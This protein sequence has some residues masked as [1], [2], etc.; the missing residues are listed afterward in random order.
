MPFKL[1]SIT[2]AP[3]TTA[4]METP[5]QNRPCSGEELLSTMP[6][7]LEMSSSDLAAFWVLPASIITQSCPFKEFVLY[8]ITSRT[9]DIQS[10]DL[11]CDAL[12]I[13]F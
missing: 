3:N 10:I 9:W 7:N 4:K 5:T 1:I 13:I 12:H 11:S 8:A 6:K 2:L